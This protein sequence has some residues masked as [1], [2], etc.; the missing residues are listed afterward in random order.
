MCTSDDDGLHGFTIVDGVRRGM[1]LAGR[2][3]TGAVHWL[4][5]AFSVGHGSVGLRAWVDVKTRKLRVRVLGTNE[6]A[7]HPAETLGGWL[8]AEDVAALGLDIHELVTR[9][10]LGDDRLSAHLWDNPVATCKTSLAIPAM[11]S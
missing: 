7:A 11:A 2:R 3:T 8:A 1:Y 10:V 9:L 6:V 4:D 5:L